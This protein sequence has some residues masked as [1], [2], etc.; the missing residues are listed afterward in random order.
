MR[1]FT[2][3]ILSIITAGLVLSSSAPASTLGQAMVVAAPLHLTL[4]PETG[5]ARS[6]RLH[7]VSDLGHLHQAIGRDL[8]VYPSHLTVRVYATH[9]SFARA[10]WR[11]QRTRPQNELDDT[12]SIVHDTLLLGPAP[13]AYLWHNLAHVYTEW[14]TDR[15]VGNRSDILPSDPWVYDGLAEYEAYRQAPR[16]LQCSGG[17]MTPFDVTQIRTARQWLV[18]RA[19]PLG[20]LEYCLSYLSVRS[21]VQRVGWPR[22]VTILH[23]SGNWHRAAERLRHISVERGDR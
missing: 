13:P 16:G 20:S 19:G 2:L 12:S 17:S 21:L 3:L 4:R 14:I 1:T 6:L 7:L 8:R 9:G 23:R 5:V 10:L 22:V 11:T 15:T 18:M